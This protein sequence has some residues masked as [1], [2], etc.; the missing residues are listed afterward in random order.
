MR[1]A[2]RVEPAEQLLAGQILAAFDE[3]AQAVVG[4]GERTQLAGFGPI[5]ELER[6]GGELGVALAQCGRAEALVRFGIALI[7]DA[8]MAAV[9]QADDCGD[10]ALLRQRAFAQI[11]FDAGAKLGEQMTKAAQR[12]YLAASCA[13]RNSGW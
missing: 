9:E 3:V 4:E 12:S 13:A 1:F 2:F 8:D 7:P 6:S 5:L 11:G 10:G